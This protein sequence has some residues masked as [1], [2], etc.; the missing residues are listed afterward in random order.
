MSSRT[1]TSYSVSRGFSLL[2]VMIATAIIS[3]GLLGVA[4]LQTTSLRHTQLT[5]ER[6]QATMLVY[7]MLDRVRANRANAA[8]YGLIR[9]NYFVGDGRTG[10][11]APGAALPAQRWAA[12]RV[13]WVCAVRR[14]LPDARGRVTVVGATAGGGG[15]PAAAATVEVRIEWCDTRQVAVG[16]APEFAPVLTPVCLGSINVILA[17]SGL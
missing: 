11:C 7:D 9:E 4:L 16:G 12:D 6:S 1:R 14:I 3:I 2:E 15:L 17:Q 10:E 5:N 8:T 13:D